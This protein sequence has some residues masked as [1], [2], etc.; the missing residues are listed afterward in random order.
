[1]RRSTAPRPLLVPLLAA[2]VL[3]GAALAPALDA[4][5][6]PRPPRATTA[7]A[8]A[9]AGIEP[10]EID[11]RATTRTR[12]PAAAA[13]SRTLAPGL[14]PRPP[15]STGPGRFA[16]AVDPNGGA[17]AYETADCSSAG[18]TITCCLH[19][20]E[21]ASCNMFKMLCSAHGGTASGDG[22]EAICVE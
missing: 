8:P 5:A 20:G 3:L 19:E 12:A 22:S 13:P 14:P 10:D 18:K 4:D 9:A 16:P 21:G 15:G 2:L 1:M 11:A 17:Q 6:T 7:T